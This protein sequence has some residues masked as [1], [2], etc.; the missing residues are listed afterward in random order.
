MQSTDGHPALRSQRLYNTA[1]PVLA[2]VTTVSGNQPLWSNNDTASSSFLEI[3]ESANE[4]CSWNNVTIADLYPGMVKVLSRLMHKASRKASSS[5]LIKRYRYGYWQPK[6]ACLNTTTERIRKFRPLKMKNSSRVTKN[7]RKKGKLHMASNSLLDDGNPQ[8]PS[9]NVEDGSRAERIGANAMETI[10]FT[11]F[12]TEETFVV[13]HLSCTPSS[14]DCIRKD[15]SSEKNSS[16]ICMVDPG[17]TFLP[18]DEAKTRKMNTL[19][20]EATSCLSLSYNSSTS[21]YLQN[22]KTSPVITSNRFLDNNEIKVFSTGISLQRSH[23]LS[24]LPVN[25]SPIKARQKCDSEFEK[26]YKELCSPKVQKP[27]ALPNIYR[28]PR[29]SDCKSHSSK[30][31]LKSNEQFD[32]IYQKLCSG[33]LLKIPTLQRAANLKKDERIQ[34][35]ETVNALVN[36][37][38]RTLPAIARIKRAAH[39]CNEDVQ[40]SPIKRFKNITE[41]SPRICQKPS[42]AGKM[43]IQKMDMTF[44]LHSP[45]QVSRLAWRCSFSDRIPKHV[46]VHQC[47]YSVH[48]Y[49]GLLL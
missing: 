11:D 32:N 40:S 17:S 6:L 44:T 37:P 24:S 42:Y 39:F 43:N 49:L 29:K 5:S 26:M 41:N 8:D 30:F 46:N 2:P 3:Y 21:S 47:F 27:F 36:S 25:Q 33:R 20:V 34:M 18:A 12:P 16:G 48:T 15:Q 13:K 4:Q 38:V 23:S 10:I 35:S 9:D 31:H 1:A 28:S 22:I 19:T 14:S 7:D 45:H